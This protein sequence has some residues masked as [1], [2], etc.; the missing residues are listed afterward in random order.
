MFVSCCCNVGIVVIV[1]IV[2]CCCRCRLSVVP[3]FS[4]LITSLTILKFRKLQQQLFFLSQFLEKH[5]GFA[6]G[7][8]TFDLD[9]FSDAEGGMFHTHS[10]LD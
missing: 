10:A 8:N 4:S 9:D 6:I 1:V 2:D 3:Y 5:A 7:E